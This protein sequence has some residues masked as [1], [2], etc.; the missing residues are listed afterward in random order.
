M[1]TKRNHAAD[2]QKRKYGK[3]NGMASPVSLR[4]VDY[5][6][7]RFVFFLLLEMERQV[8]R[9]RG[10]GGVKKQ[11]SQSAKNPPFPANKRSLPSAFYS[12]D[13]VYLYIYRNGISASV[14]FPVPLTCNGHGNYH[15]IAT[16]VSGTHEVV[17]G[18]E[19]LI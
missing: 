13:F 6:R 11:R 5:S 14:A 19:C 3:T 12:N 17:K 2:V 7:D 1:G 9:Q 18:A 8:E 10:G 4:N 16:S 15:S